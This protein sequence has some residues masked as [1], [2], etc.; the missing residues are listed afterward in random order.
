ML[1]R[2]I[3]FFI[4]VGLFLGF[5][6]MGCTS[7]QEHLPILRV[8]M[9]GMPISLDPARA[10]DGLAL[11]VLANVFDGL[12]QYD[13]KGQ[14]KNGV[15]QSIEISPDHKKYV[16]TLRPEAK[17]SDGKPLIAKDFVLGFRRALA[18]QTASK[19]SSSLLVIRGAMAYRMGKS[20]ELPG[21]KEQDGK[22]VI[23]LD[24]PVSYFLQ[25]MT[26]GGALPSRQDVLDAHAGNWPD[27]TR[28]SEAPGVGPYRITSYQPDQKIILER[29]PYYWGHSPAIEKVEF[30]IVSDDSAGANLFNQGKLDILSSIPSLDFQ[31]WKKEGKVQTSPFLA[32]YYIG[33]NCRKPP[34]DDRDFRAA[35][36]AV[37]D[38]EGIVAALMT[39]EI[40]A[41]SWIPP[42]L[43][44]YLS[45]SEATKRADQQAVAAIT[46]VKARAPSLPPIAFSFDSGERNALIAEKIEQDLKQKLGLKLSLTNQD[47]KS[48]IKALQT[49]APPL[50]RLAWQTP[51]LDPIFHLQVLM[52]SHPANFSGCGSPE[53]DRKIT[54]IETL[55]PGPEREKKIKEA[56]E[57]I[58]EKDVFLAPIFHYVQSYAVSP[59]VKGFQ[60]NPFSVIRFEE[61]GALQ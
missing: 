40:P 39:D 7:K 54:E 26:L 1:K 15:A 30:V 58:S 6:V 3:L 43:E 28:S 36:S 41:R 34:F 4:F 22:L 27:G 33:F 23:E 48:H 37:I 60:V 59:R 20:P 50:Y 16:F 46:K 53:Y 44:G 11:K 29:N 49:D 51:F 25:L 18:P 10:E 52:T 17:W 42:G 14:L 19:L 13:G 24:R 35:V 2:L 38:R 31:K 8:Q 21:V 56:Q 57:L 9:K 5:L 32:T 55:S 45:F 61:L 47:W 12:V